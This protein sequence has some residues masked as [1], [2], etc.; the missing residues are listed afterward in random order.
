MT[1]TTQANAIFGRV[2]PHPGLGVLDT[3]ARQIQAEA[4]VHDT[5]QRIRR[6]VKFPGDTPRT[7]R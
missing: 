6:S 4:L 7:R 5:C 2:P 3:Q 1:R